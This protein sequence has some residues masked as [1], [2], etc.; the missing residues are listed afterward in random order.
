MPTLDLAI[1]DL[2]AAHGSFASTLLAESEQAVRQFAA[3]TLPDLVKAVGP[4][5]E[6]QGKAAIIA[7]IFKVVVPV[8]PKD[9]GKVII[10]PNPV[11]WLMGRHRYHGKVRRALKSRHYVRLADFQSYRDAKFKNVGLAASGYAAAAR[12]LGVDL[13]AWMQDQPEG[14]GEFEIER[15]PDGITI[16]F[17]NQVP[18]ISF[19]PDTATKTG[20]AIQSKAGKF[21]D[22]S[23]EAWD[24]AK[25]DF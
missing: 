2:A 9:E 8:K 25:R 7:D 23:V 6:G 5:N 15:R 18:W 16:R 21:Y 3:L 12:E 11:R 20:Y 22:L 19:L 10:N 14:E 24:R 1:P 4:E 13:P 17:E